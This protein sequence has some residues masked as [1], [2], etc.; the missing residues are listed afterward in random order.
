MKENNCQCAICN[1]EAS[2][3]DSFSTQTAQIHFKAL[4]NHYPVLNHFSSPI[5]LVSHLHEHGEAANHNA[6]REILQTL[7][8][9]VAEKPFEEIGQQLILLAF[10]PVIHKT[11]CEVVQQFP[12]LALEEIAQQA[13]LLFLETVRSPEILS[14]NGVLLLRLVS[15]FRRNLFRWA[16]Q[17]TRPSPIVEISANTPEPL[18]DENFEDGVLLRDFFEQAFSSGL[19][20]EAQHKLL[21]QFKGEGVVWK[22]LGDGKPGPSALALYRRVKR[23][24]YRL[25]RAQAKGALK[26]KASAV[27]LDASAAQPQKKSCK[28]R[29]ISPSPWAFS[30][31]EKGFSPE[32]SRPMPQIETS[33]TRIVV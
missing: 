23:T 31:S 7:I 6:S 11:C 8:H 4:S 16:M 32:L 27:D 10:T 25:R 21:L 20:S 1:V 19:L 9:A 22:E 12:T 17:E 13:W 14:Q 3:L 2:L 18:S 26:S 33:V 24:I 30:N 29:S 28:R 5:E 15:R